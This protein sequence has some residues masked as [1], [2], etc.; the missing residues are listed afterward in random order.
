MKKLNII[1]TL[2]VFLILLFTSCTTTNNNQNN[3]QK[4][5]YIISYFLNGESIDLQPGT[6][7]ENE[8]CN[9]PTPTVEEGYI[10]LGWYDNSNYTGSEISSISTTD[11]GHKT[12]FGKTIKVDEEPTNDLDSL[13]NALNIDNYTYNFIEDA[14]DEIYEETYKVTIDKIENIYSFGTDTYNDYLD[15]TEN[16]YKIVYSDGYD[17]YYTLEGDDYYY[18]ILEYMIIINLSSLDYNHFEYNKTNNSYILKE[19]YLQTDLYNFM[20]TYD[21]EVFSSC[22]I[23]LD[24]NFLSTITITS[25]YTYSGIKYDS[26]YEFEFSDINKT[27]IEIPNATYDGSYES[28]EITIN[29]VYNSYIGSDVTITGVVTGIYGNNFY[30]SDETGSILIYM[31]STSDYN[32]LVEDNSVLTISGEISSYKDIYQIINVTSVVISSKSLNITS[33][34]I[35]D[36]SQNYLSNNIGELIDVEEVILK[37]APSSTNASSDISFTVELNGNEVNVFISKH[38][39]DT[40]T[41]QLLDY[42]STLE[43]NDKLNL[44]NLHIGKY[45]N[46]QLIVTSITEFEKTDNTPSYQTGIVTYPSEL[47]VEEGTTIDEIYG[48]I[49]VYAKYSNNKEQL[50]ATSDYTKQTNYKEEIGTYT[51]TYK[52]DSFTITVQITVTEKGTGYIKPTL[53]EQPLRDEAYKFNFTRG[54][55][56]IGEPKVLVIPVEFTDYPAPSTMVEDLET[57]F[58]GTSS[59]TGWESLQSY[60]Y[61]SSY[62]K[63]NITGTVLEP[64]NTGKKSTTYTYDSYADYEIIKDALEYYDSTINYDDY[65]TDKDGYIDSIYIIYTRDYNETSDLWWAYTYEYFTESIEYY[66][67]VEADFYIFM[68]Y[69]FFFD[70]LNEKTIKYNCETLIHE[71]GHLLGLDDY[72]D[73]DEGNGPDGGIGGGDMMDFNVGDHNA[74]SKLILGWVS[75]YVITGNS[76]TISLNSFEQSGD[77][78]IIAKNWNGSVFSE[79]FIIDF[80]TPTGLNEFCK[81]YNGLFST[82]G[83]RIYHI[84]ATTSLDGSETSLW[85]ITKYNN[86]DTTYQLI[87]L[88]EADGRNDILDMGYS[89]NSDLFK[90]SDICQNLKWCDNTNANFTLKVNTITNDIANITIT[91]KK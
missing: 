38:L 8:G 50:L 83:I 68:S 66:D 13:K 75:P 58:F 1:K 80:Y 63:L 91:I 73:Y 24:K 22:N 64:Y 77:C 87:S 10:F 59:E 32:L 61:K 69:Q 56:S 47:S 44:Y 33:T 78:I 84:N 81:G 34:K 70:E 53:S 85:E 62:G 35:N 19:E 29:E 40:Y 57:A 67:N 65:D 16:T 15:M 55:P 48:M 7:Y 21:G 79:Y 23:T 60:Y 49:S 45:T 28:N 6:Y 12:Y 43:E 54:L 90:A 20:P 41:Y 46:Y 36:L 4:N 9:L 14:N 74:Y 5:E 25:N 18:S 76:L 72:Y 17:W 89:E 71:T 39:D 2:F 37:K 26:V 31:G 30:L 27:N 88:V 42:I 82:S 51:I 11:K 86:S 3:Q 52:Q